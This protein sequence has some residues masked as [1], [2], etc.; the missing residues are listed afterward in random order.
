[1][2]KLN[3]DKTEMFVIGSNYRTIPALPDLNMGST[4]ITSADHLKN[5]G[6]VCYG[7]TYNKTLQKITP[8]WC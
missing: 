3:D 8:L 7:T 5:L 6:Q 2:L 4:V 1:M